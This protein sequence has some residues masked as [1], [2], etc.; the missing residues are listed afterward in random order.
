MGIEVPSEKGSLPQVAP[1]LGLAVEKGNFFYQNIL[2]VY[3]HLSFITPDGKL[4]QT[5]IVKYNTQLLKKFGMKPTNEIQKVADIW[6]YP[7]DFFNPL[8]DLT[9][10]L[11]ITGNTRS[12]HWYSRTWTESSLLRTKIS[13]MSHRIFGMSLHNLKVYFIRG[14]K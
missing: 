1:G 4:N 14:R 9:G 5:T 11:K 10:K 8:D 3:A 13:R 12:I 2:D 6:I 7:C